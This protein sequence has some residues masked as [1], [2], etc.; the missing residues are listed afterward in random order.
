MGTDNLSQSTENP[1]AECKNFPNKTVVLTVDRLGAG[2]LGPYG[3]TWI[4]T[5]AMNLLASQSVL[6]ENCLIDSANPFGF[7]QSLL[8]GVHAA[9]MHSQPLSLPDMVRRQNGTSLLITDDAQ[10]AESEIGNWFDEVIL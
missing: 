8:T 7:L 10:L 4:E 9:Q 5:P 1:I 3:N 6:F 2:F